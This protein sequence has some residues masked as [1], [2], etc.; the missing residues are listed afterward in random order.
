MGQPMNYGTHT[1]EGLCYWCHNGDH[2]GCPPS[3]CACQPCNDARYL[4]ALAFLATQ[5]VKV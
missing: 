4:N 5:K 3:G 1:A 2:T